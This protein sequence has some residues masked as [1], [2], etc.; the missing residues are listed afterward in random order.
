MLRSTWILVLVACIGGSAAAQEAFLLPA[1]LAA[2]WTD[3][4]PFTVM[5]ETPLLV[6]DGDL[7]AAR[8]AST[9]AHLLSFGEATS[10]RVVEARAY[11][12][13]ERH[14]S[15]PPIVYDR[16]APDSLG[17]E[18]YVLDVSPERITLSANEPA[19][20]FYATQTLR[21]LLPP[22]VEYDAAFPVPLTV[23]SGR[24]VDRPRFSWRGM[25]LDVAR[26]FFGP[27]DVRRVIDLMALHKLNRLHLHLSDDQGW[28]I[29]IPGWSRLTEIGG[30]TEVG[31]SPGGFF[32]LDDYAALVQY[33]AERFVTVVPE[34]DL[35]GHTNA[36]LASYAELNC[37]G[38]A[39]PL[40]TGTS[41]GFSTVCVEREAT[42]RFVTD[43]VR[44][45]AEA[46]PGAYFHLGGDE[47]RELSPEQYA[48]FMARAQAIVAEYGK[49]VI[50][51]DEIAEV[52][53]LPQ[54]IV[55][56]WRPAEAETQA[57]IR[58]AVEAG[59]TVVLSPADRVYLDI[60]YDA[61]TV[62]GLS[63]AGLNSVRDA[64]EWDP[65]TLLPGVA[66]AAIEGIEAPL[67]S[68]TISTRADLEFMAFP[69]LAGVA[70]LGWAPAEAHDWD[71]YRVRLGAQ[72]PRWTALGINFYRSPGV[73]WAS[74]PSRD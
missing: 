39:P 62:L 24:V 50:G 25:M 67:W 48:A 22:A 70:D 31:G 41:V 66:A 27:A 4:A 60:K 11:A 30:S 2:T 6:P 14:S 45:L 68:E 3:A 19:G 8:I 38:V 23:P 54:S 57:Q 52:E 1:P 26:H 56:V 34:I 29:E 74:A 15:L 42:Y 12:R 69:R 5:P 28:R 16:Q 72:A 63:W 40:Y 20:W 7:D 53:L 13:S 49:R 71:T 35:P 10:P 36:A 55:Q 33:A 58:E 46:S 37:D 43:V 32:S 73:P 64:Y 17:A 18:G 61:S 47:V 51:W 59:A 9:L 65:T 21:Q 44:T